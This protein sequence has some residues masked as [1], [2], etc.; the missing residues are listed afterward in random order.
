V[1]SKA[2]DALGERGEAELSL[3][4]NLWSSSSLAH[5]VE[6]SEYSGASVELTVPTVRFRGSQKSRSS[7]T[8]DRA[9]GEGDGERDGHEAVERRSLAVL[10]LG[11]ETVLAACDWDCR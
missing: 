1:V 11:S 5:R 6:R 8:M 10:L 3:R 7:E 2:N 9:Y 4:S